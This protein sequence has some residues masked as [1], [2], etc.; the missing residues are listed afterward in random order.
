M[1][2]LSNFQR[3]PHQPTGAGLSW[4]TE[5][6][7]E[8]SDF[9]LKLRAFPKQLSQLT[10]VFLLRRSVFAFTVLCLCALLS[11][12]PA[13]A[14]PLSKKKATAIVLYDQE[15]MN[16]KSLST[17]SYFSGVSYTHVKGPANGAA[18]ASEIIR[19]ELAR[20][21]YKVLGNTVSLQILR[22]RA[23]SKNLPNPAEITKLSK[24]YKIGQYIDG[25][26]TALDSTKNDFGMYTGTAAVAVN[27][28]DNSGR[29]LYSDSVIAKGVGITESEAEMKAVREAALQIAE[30]LV[31]KS[32]DN[33]SGFNGMYVSVSGAGNFRTV[34]S[35]ERACGTVYGVTAVKNMQYKNGTALL[36]VYGKFD[37]QELQDAITSK[38]EYSTIRQVRDGTVYVDLY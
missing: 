2:S 37:V 21:G 12:F 33:E 34:Q 13:E 9:L 18:L 14:S 23:K 17:W 38:V 32:A 20:G 8:T 27:A 35:V 15:S 10:E 24:K 26:V 25:T 4:L 30:K 28:Y 19:G 6:G 1:E 3:V 29:T 16:I 11:A 36:A 22:A 7:C 31:D 5:Q